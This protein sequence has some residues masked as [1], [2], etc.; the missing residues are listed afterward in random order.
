MF[1]N[2]RLINWCCLCWHLKF[3]SLKLCRSI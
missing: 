3:I 1:G 2:I